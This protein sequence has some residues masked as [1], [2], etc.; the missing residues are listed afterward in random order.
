MARIHAYTPFGDAVRG[1]LEEAFP[2]REVVCWSHPAEL[3]DGL[4][5]VEH[6]LAL[7]P[8]DGH[9]ADARRLRLL[10]SFGAGIDHLLPLD[11]LPPGVAVANAAGLVAEPMSELALALAMMLRKRVNV[12]LSDQRRHRWH[13]YTPPTVDGSILG[14]LGLGH[15]GSALARRAHAAGMR[16]I[17][18]RRRPA[19][20]ACVEEVFPPRE[21]AE[22]LAR[23]DVA[24]CLLPLTRETRGLL[25][26][27]MLAHLRP[28]ACLINLGR[29]GIV[30]ERALA[31]MLRGGRLSGAALD[32]F[33]A[34][35]QPPDSPLWDVPNLVMTPHVGGAYPRYMPDIARLFAD[36]VRRVEAGRMPLT[37]VNPVRGY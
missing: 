21:T 29:G 27:A 34:E 37:P 22:V 36:N 19:P 14:V 4:P 3:I 6:L 30:D 7:N 8:P 1:A 35:P 24:V 15:I 31:D 32:V 13:R 23:A 33:E 9:W 2:D 12:A 5:E 26:A 18:T 25:D 20:V 16:V 17:G 10:H 28:E 11:D